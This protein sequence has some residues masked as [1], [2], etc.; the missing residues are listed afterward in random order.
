M[1]MEVPSP[2]KRKTI[3]ISHG[4]QCM[5]G[6]RFGERLRLLQERASKSHAKPGGGSTS[7]ICQRPLSGSE[8]WDEHDMTNAQRK[9]SVKP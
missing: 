2:E 4:F 7:F 5:L 6:T 8:Y 1:C 9:H 3:Q